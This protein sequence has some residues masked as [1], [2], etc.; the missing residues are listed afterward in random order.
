MLSFDGW[1]CRF[2]SSDGSEVCKVALH[3][4]RAG[5]RAA[6]TL[7]YWCLKEA[8]A[9]LTGS[10]QL[11]SVWRWSEVQ[12]GHWSFDWCTARW[13][14]LVLEFLRCERVACRGRCADR[15]VIE[16]VLCLGIDISGNVALEVAGGGGEFLEPW[17]LLFFR[18]QVC[19]GSAGALSSAGH[20]FGVVALQIMIHD[21][22]RC[23]AVWVSTAGAARDG[24]EFDP[25]DVVVCG[26]GGF[27]WFVLR[28]VCVASAEGCSV[29]V[30]VGYLSLVGVF[31][32]P[33]CLSLCLFVFC[34]FG[35][36]PAF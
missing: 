21:V 6:G 31:G 18:F 16:L 15:L 32:W 13:P 36:S 7:T 5:V 20:E 25:L 2:L 12:S 23:E 1:L 3:G 22:P 29:G 11:A 30:A 19:C 27:L 33:V 17:V 9:S 4:G 34:A 26:N 24:V 8:G 35:C 14:C 10:V 28:V